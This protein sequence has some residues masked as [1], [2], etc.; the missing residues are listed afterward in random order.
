MVISEAVRRPAPSAQL[1]RQRFVVV[2]AL[3]SLSLLTIIDRVAISAAKLNMSH[4]L[5]LSD[6]NFGWIFGAFA[7]GYALFQLPSGWLVDRFG[8]RALVAVI[9]GMWSLFTG[10]TTVAGT[11]AMLVAVRFLFGAAES[12]AYPASAKVIKTWLPACERGVAQGV[13]FAGSR[14]GAAIGLTLTSWSV[15]QFG[16]RASFLVLSAAGLLWMAGWLLWFR[17]SPEESRWT[18][19]AE[20][21][22]ISDEEV[23]R[24][25]VEPC[26]D[27][28]PRP[29]RFEVAVLMLQ[30]AAS[31]YTFFVC[32][33]WLLPY[34]RERYSMDAAE[35]GMMAAI[36]L[37]FGAAS[38]WLSGIAVDRLYRAGKLR[39]SRVIPASAGFL[40]AALSLCIAT[41]CSTAWAGVLFFALATFGVDFTLSPSWTLCIDVSGN[42][43]ATLTG[44]MNMF[45][46]LG[47]FLS[48]LSFPFLFRWTGHSDTFFYSAA[49]LNLCASF[50]WF[51]LRNRPSARMNT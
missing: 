37:Y 44:A 4:E 15:A 41:Q 11:V 49:A 48:S 8:A 18:S 40:L 32:F 17:N 1:T 51:T 36:P 19:E 45:G 30:Y 28:N 10:L 22:L 27:P 14:L 3:F 31:N 43:T 39:D 2:V 6:V 24:H 23:V 9:V 20:R 16:W 21:R 38:N 12:G 33:T 34:I 35:A 47:S 13:V 5:G 46:N 50:L 26:R 7:L 29:A 25:A 42:R